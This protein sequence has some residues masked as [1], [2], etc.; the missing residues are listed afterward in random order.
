MKCLRTTS[1]EQ[2][3]GEWLDEAGIVAAFA[4][5]VRNELGVQCN[6]LE[7]HYENVEERESTLQREVHTSV[8]SFEARSQSLLKDVAILKKAILLEAT[9]TSDGPPKLHVREPEGFTRN[10]NVKILE[11]FL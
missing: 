7:Q 6:L 5:H 2:M 9:L 3:F 1:L 4:E 11:N 10:H 8:E